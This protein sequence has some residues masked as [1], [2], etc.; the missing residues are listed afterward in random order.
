VPGE[1]RPGYKHVAVRPCDDGGTAE[2]PV[3]SHLVSA[4]CLGD[5]DLGV[6]YALGRRCDDVLGEGQDVEWALA[7]GQAVLL[8]SRPIT[9]LAT[10]RRAGVA[11][12]DRA[13]ASTRRA[14]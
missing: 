5:A 12:P 14:P 10:S 13:P 4:L 3:A 1:R 2:F 7:R 9:M 11:G 8:Q 6:L